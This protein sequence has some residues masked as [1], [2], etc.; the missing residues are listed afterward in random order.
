MKVKQQSTSRNLISGIN[1]GFV[2]KLVTLWM[3]LFSPAALALPHL[4]ILCS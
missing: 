4:D 2:L 1:L 3:I